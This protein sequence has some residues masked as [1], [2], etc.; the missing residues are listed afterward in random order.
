MKCV[1]VHEAL[2][3]L[4]AAFLGIERESCFLDGRKIPAGRAGVAV[5]FLGELS[6]SDPMVLGLDG[7]QDSPLFG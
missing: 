3:A 4:L 7:P 6:D 5:F 1:A 2:L